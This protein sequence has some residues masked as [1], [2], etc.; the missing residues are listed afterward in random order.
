MLDFPTMGFLDIAQAM[1][2]LSAV[3]PEG[4]SCIHSIPTYHILP[5]VPCALGMQLPALM[6][7]HP[8]TAVFPSLPARG[9]DR[10]IHRASRGRLDLELDGQ[11]LRYQVVYQIEVRLFRAAM[12]SF[13]FTLSLAALG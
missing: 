1:L 2:L 10:P 9:R 13:A 3:F 6:L 8:F 11:S 7:D 12:I 5:I 4:S